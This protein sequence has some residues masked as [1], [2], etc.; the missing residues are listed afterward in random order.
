MLRNIP[1]SHK[2]SH[3]SECTSFIH[4]LRICFRSN[5]KAFA[6]PYE[7]IENSRCSTFARWIILFVQHLA[8]THLSY[9]SYSCLVAL[10]FCISI[11]IHGYSFK[12]FHFH[13]DSTYRR[14]TGWWRDDFYG[15]C[16]LWTSRAKASIYAYWTYL[17]LFWWM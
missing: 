17:Y 9:V 12:H 11:C 4:H 10:V 3:L 16:L 8:F 1:S 5:Q 14:A 2:N 13:R 7:F 6:R 15:D